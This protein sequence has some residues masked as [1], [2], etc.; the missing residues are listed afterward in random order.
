MHALNNH[1]WHTPLA[2]KPTGS[3]GLNSEIVRLGLQE[4]IWVADQLWQVADLQMGREFPWK[5]CQVIAQRW[6]LEQTHW[7][8]LWICGDSRPVCSEETWTLDGRWEGCVLASLV[9]EQGPCHFCM[10]MKDDGTLSCRFR[11]GD[12]MWVTS[13][14][15]GSCKPRKLWID[16]WHLERSKA[17]V[18]WLGSIC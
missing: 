3:G 7:E 12:P 17:G 6:L 5:M 11:A 16:W 8:C 4:G 15:Y 13:P 18:K 14:I 1:L 2:F 9:V 10:W